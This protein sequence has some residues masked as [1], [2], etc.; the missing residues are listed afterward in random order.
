MAATRTRSSLPRLTGNGKELDLS[1]EAFGELRR[2]DALLGDF[3]ALQARMEED[4]YLYLPGFF[5]REDVLA[6]RRVI[7][8]RMAEVGLL[9]PRYPTIEAVA[10]EGLK[11]AFRPEFALNNPALDRV[12]YGE[13]MMTF[14]DGLLGGPSRHYDFTWLRVVAP[15]HGSPTHCDIV[16]MGRGTQNLY[17]SWTPL[18]DVPL[19]TGGLVILEDSQRLSPIRD[20]YSVL[21]VD[22][23]CTNHNNVN[24]TKL[25]G[26]EESG[27]ITL[28]AVSLREQLNRRW[29]TSPYKMGDVVVFSV[30]TIHGGL[31]NHSNTIRLSSDTRYQLASEPIDERWIG[32]NPPAHG[33]NAKRGLIC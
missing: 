2:S 22:K 4:G 5:D 8:D 11:S 13:R 18:G 33:P 20:T 21:D 15:G 12:I 29:L 24:Q 32:E 31:D 16:Y 23:L 3:P 17:T 1:P 14:Y 28:D 7:T 26:F 27:A 30:F 6:A 9:D 10:K 19:E 25:H